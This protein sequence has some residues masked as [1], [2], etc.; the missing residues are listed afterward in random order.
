MSFVRVRNIAVLWVRELVVYLLVNYERFELSS[1]ILEI[2]QVWLL[3]ILEVTVDIRH[4][5]SFEQWNYVLLW[6]FL[7]FYG[8]RRTKRSES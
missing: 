1:Q 6:Q 7:K 2:S 4:L 8:R 3:V 5:S